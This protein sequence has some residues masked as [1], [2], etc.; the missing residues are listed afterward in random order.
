MRG[1]AIL[2]DEVGLGKTIEAG[3]VLSELR[4]RGLADR[5]LVVVPAG[6]TQQWQEERERKFA[7]PAIITVSG[8]GAEVAGRHQPAVIASPATARRDPH[9]AGVT[10]QPGH[11]R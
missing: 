3:L 4:I 5:S 10:P 2:A 7:L 8:G 6:L 9:G 1:R 11:I